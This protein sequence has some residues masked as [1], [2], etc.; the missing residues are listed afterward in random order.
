MVAFT[1]HDLLFIL[2]GIDVSEQH[3]A[4]SNADAIGGTWN[5]I[6]IEDSRIILRSLL[7][8][9]LEPIGMRTITGQLNNLEPA[10]T[11]FGAVGEFPRLLDPDYRD[12]GATG[13]PEDPIDING[14]APGGIVDNTDY[15]QSVGS[16]GSP[17]GHVV[18][19]DPRMISNLIVDISIHNAAAADRAGL[20]LGDVAGTYD[21]GEDGIIGTDDDVGTESGALIIDPNGTPLD[22]DDFL[23]IPNVAPDEGLSAPFNAWMT[24]FGQ[25][26]D[27][28]LD[29]VGK[30]GSGTIFMP[31][32][33]DDPLVAGDDGI[34]GT[35]DD[36]APQQRF[37]VLTRSDVDAG[38]DGVLGTPDDVA[39]AFN[40][41]SPFVDQNQ[42]YTSHPSMQLFVREYLDNNEPLLVDHHGNPIPIGA[43]VATG[44]LIEGAGGG[45]ANWG[46]VKAQA[47]LR[48]G[49]ELTDADGL[50]MPLFAVD[51][52]GEMIRGA[53]GL[54]QF[55]M[56]DGT[57]IE[58][59]LTSPVSL[60]DAVLA[61][62]APA[63]ARTGFSFLV[64][65]NNDANPVDSQTG[66]MLLR[67]EDGDATNG[68]AG[69]G[70]YDG[71]LL[72]AHY[73][74]GDGR[75]NENF[76]LTA[77][78][79]VFHQEHNRVVEHTKEVL[80]SQANNV[81]LG[82]L[83]D[84]DGT[85]AALDLLNG[86]LRVP[87]ATFPSTPGEIAGLVWDGD[88]LFQAAKFATEMQYQHLVFEEFGRKVQPLIDIFASFEPSIDAS[89]VAE[90]AH[91]VYRFGHSMLTE[92]VDLMDVDGNLTE[93][94]LIEAFLNPL[95]FHQ[96]VNEDGEIPGGSPALNASEAA[97]AIARGMTRQVGS[98]ID[99]FV[100]G[101]LRNNL[102]G[103]PLDLAAINI[104]RGRDTGVP[105]LNDARAE[106]FAGTGD[107][108][109]KPYDSWFD[110]AIH[111]KNEMSIV[112]FIAAYGQ[113]DTITTA[114]SIEMKRAASWTLVTGEATSGTD[115]N[116]DSYA[117]SVGTTSGDRLEFLH[118]RDDDGLG[119]DWSTAESGLN[120]VDFWI[121]GLAEAIEPFGGMLGSTFNFVFEEQME[122][123]QDGDRFYYLGRT[124]GL[125]FLTQ[126][127]ENSFA[128]M[129]IRNTSIGD[130]HD[131]DGLGGDHLP[132]DIFSSPHYILEVNQERQV[133][134]IDLPDAAIM[135]SG[136][137]STDQAS[138]GTWH[139]VTFTQEISNAVVAMMVNTTADADPTTVR[140]R[141][142][143]ETGF[144][145]QMDEYDYL[146][147]IHGL[148]TIS[149]VAVAEGEH[150]LADG[151]IIKAGTATENG[152]GSITVP[153]GG[154]TAFTTTP[155]VL[156]QVSSVNEETAV[157]SQVRTSGT[158]TFN[159]RLREQEA[160]SNP[161]GPGLQGTAIGSN[162]HAAETIGWIA[163]QQGSGALL[164][165]GTA[166]PVDE[167]PVTLTHS[168]G[169]TNPVFIGEIQTP[170]G[171]ANPATVRGTA[172]DPNAATVFLEEEASAS[173][174]N[175]SNE[176]VGFL[177]LPTGVIT[178][179]NPLNGR[180]DPDDG[181]LLVDTVIRQD[182]DNDGDN[183]YLRYTGGDHVVLGGTDEADTL[184]G[185]IGD[186]TL[187]G[188]D[189]DDRIEG[190]DGADILLGG[191]GDD[192]ITDLGG[193]D[194]I[195]GQAGN[196]AIYSGAGEDLILAGSGQDFVLQGEDLSE[197]FG[198]TGNDFMHLGSE[199]NLSFGGEGN[200]WMEGGDG[201]NLLQ[202]DNGDPFLNSTVGGHDVFISGQGDDDYDTEG[203]DDIMEGSDGVQRF[204]GVNGFD[205]ATY[206]DVQ[207][208]INVDMLLR[209]FDETPIPPSNA[210]I[211]DRFDS[212]E[213]LSGGHGSD[214]LRGSD[215]IR[216]EIEGVNNGNDSVLRTDERFELIRGLRE[217]DNGGLFDSVAIFDSTVTE[218]GEGD[219]ILGGSGSDLIEGRGGDDI[220]DGDLKLDVRIA[221]TVQVD[222]GVLVT[223]REM[224]GELFNTNPDG[225]ANYASPYTTPGGAT[226]L[227]EAVFAGEINPGDLNIVREILDESAASDYDI[228][229]FN[230]ALAEYTIEGR[231]A[232]AGVDGILGT[233]D[234]V[235]T[236]E[237]ADT[238]L[239]GY[240][241]VTH[242]SAPGANDGLGADGTDLVRNIERLQFAELTVEIPVGVTGSSSTNG[243]AG[244]QPVIVLPGT[245]TPALDP[246]VGDELEV[247]TS[248]ITDPN[249]MTDPIFVFTWQI[250]EAPGT[251]IDLEQI[252]LADITLL[253]GNPITVPPE[254]AGFPLRVRAM[255][256]DDAGVIEQVFSAATNITAPAAADVGTPGPDLLLG[257]PDNDTINGLAGNDQ[258]FALAGND[259]VNAGGNDDVVFGGD[260][261][262]TIRGNGG[263]DELFGEGGNDT[264]DG[265][266]GADLLDG[267]DGND[268]LRGDNGAD[269]ILGGA[270]EDRL[271]GGDGADSL[272]GGAD[273]D[274]VRGQGGDDE[275]LWAV[276]DGRDTVIG[277]G[278][279]DV[280]DVT[281][282]ALVAET[283]RV[284]AVTA[285]NDP[286]AL[287][288]N[289]IASTLDPAT[290]I[291]VLH[292]GA[293]I[294]ELR[295]IEELVINGT[296]TPAT[297]G[298]AAGD[299]VLVQG[300]FTNTSLALA[301]ITVNGSSGD[302]VV[303]ISG[304]DSAHRIVFRSFGGN[305][306]VVGNLRAQDVI[307]LAPGLDPA[308]FGPP[309]YNGNNTW[310]IS[311][312]GGGQ[313]I[314]YA[315]GPGAAAPTLAAH[316]ITEGFDFTVDDV[317]ELK[318]IVRGLPSDNLS[319]EHATGVRDLEGT[320]N[321]TAHPD[322]GAADQE[323]I[324]LTDARYGE[325]DATIG[326]HKVNPIFDGLDPREIS[327]ILG[328]QEDDLG[329]NK[330]G[331][332]TFFMA[333]GQYV[334]HGLDFLP[335]T[336][337]NGTIEIG[338][339]PQDDPADLT[340]GEVSSIA[341]GASEHLNKASPFVDQNQAYGSTE[342]VG[343]FLRESDGNQGHGPRLLSG[344]PDP[345]SPEY[346]LLPTLRELIIHH[347][348]NDTIFSDPVHMPGGPTSF[349]DYFPGLVTE[350]VGPGGTV[351]TINEAMVPALNADFMGSGHTLVGDANP[352]INLLDHYVAGDLRANENYSLTS[353]HTIWARNHNHHVE[354]L[355]ERGFDGTPDELFE[356]AK[357]VNEAEYQ[358]V[359]YTEFV[360]QLLGGM[361][362]SGGNHGHDDYDPTVDARISH[363]FAAAAYR[364]GHSL[365]S[366]TMTVIDENGDPQQIP[367]TDIFLN[368]TNDDAAFTVPLAQ[369]QQQGYIPQPGYEQI[370]VNGVVE[371]ISGQ[372]AEEVDFNIVDAVRD[373]LVRIRA[374]LF[375]F[376]VARGWD[377]GLGTLNQVRADLLKSSDPY[378]REA[379]GG[380]DADLTPYS[381]WEDFRSRNNLS[382]NVMGQLIAAYPDLELQTPAEIAAFQ[383]ANPY[384]ELHGP[385]GNIVRGIDRLDVWVG[386]LAEAHVNDGMVGSTFWVILHEQ[387]DRLQEGD[388][389]YYFDRVEKFDFY[390][391]VEDQTFSDIIERNTGLQ[392]LA[393]EIFS[394]PG[395]GEV[396]DEE[397][398]VGTNGKDT[399]FAFDEDATILGLGGHD[400]I[401]G[402]A[403]ADTIF[404]GGGNDQIVAGDGNDVIFG[405]GGRDVILAEGG[406]DIIYA[407]GGRDRVMSG[408]GNDFIEAGNGRD[409]IDAGDG[410]DTVLAEVGDGN[411]TIDGGAGNDTLDYSAIDS[412]IIA[413]LGDDFFGF[414]SS[415]DSG[416][417]SITNFE[418]I[419]TGS[420][421]DIIY[422]N[423]S[424]NVFSGGL[425]FD[426]FVF[427]SIEQ[428]D[429]D[430]IVDFELGDAIDLTGITT[431]Y[432]FGGFGDFELL[433][434]G[435]TTFTQAGQLIVRKDSGS[436]FVE[437]NVDGDTD[438]DF[439][440]K[441]SGISKLEPLDFFGVS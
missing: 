130:Q 25:F 341:N 394:V 173:G 230:G 281:G 393:E 242:N 270:G 203:G 83:G 200:D 319:E 292:N 19:T 164:T 318:N 348:Q 392:G 231:V 21:A 362:G 261:N 339:D 333:F 87:V 133:T 94:G 232:A 433:A 419:V 98:E 328:D 382:L 305:D 213:G 253:Q 334:D 302:D 115:V 275:I 124:G 221:G 223:A 59:N 188:E 415:V 425:G 291:V 178:A 179:P 312:I 92:T 297:G 357:I 249:G 408:D 168:G 252:G 244:G 186:D 358:R 36:L 31:L 424:A 13:N 18:D 113:H 15:S 8:N 300:D 172:F 254:A 24:F 438:A 141:N 439:T 389:F 199:S 226:T 45:M 388:R 402:G 123:L 338:T 93:A 245:T 49:I 204:E 90:F 189:G 274:D 324:R 11:E 148:E 315:G 155:V 360:D 403:H 421:D 192:I 40:F 79:H 54:P 400:T 219:I 106:F 296:D 363:E 417:D 103:L 39:D 95:G 279:T 28:G 364:F 38:P 268:L 212:V 35:I 88:R 345:S 355:L 218:W 316:S 46:E 170:I 162:A 201:N 101:A 329:P 271:R 195:Q 359:V 248:A 375:A 289:P 157:T 191:D 336:A 96:S 194:N 151:S 118:S 386:G 104:A 193:E 317:R 420:G 434:E 139:T 227:Q 63:A 376:N 349:Q 86:Y 117:F 116:G 112:N 397:Q 303:D 239:D 149:W 169:Y 110:F 264:I 22:H 237:A 327:N 422:A 160:G 91:T 122:D 132:G 33:D 290:E 85:A 175:T 34:F 109:L 26:F 225:S 229:E 410:D 81:D 416:E 143:T 414:V 378:V 350:S 343:Q 366:Q 368:P 16:L 58:G 335:K 114:T 6:D 75:V 215:Q 413:D 135:E 76:G 60:A 405:D 167:T 152:S 299:T 391:Q 121:G 156:S 370:G 431:N 321:N 119:T 284:V 73:I 211:L 233:A 399:L 323:F 263:L 310:T 174:T 136:T 262:D 129:I 427:D 361:L 207:E 240:I 2:E 42:T 266:N 373:D 27:H 216:L 125:N 68:G 273:D 432:N 286:V 356:A 250:E 126:L 369:L 190:G 65:I 246:Q 278:G 51:E 89:I 206:R 55:V 372:P 241:T 283:F 381:S 325:F 41:T 29:L 304:L 298:F 7:P 280:F 390:D 3:A 307:E 183:D 429:G 128:N 154:S 320:G 66:L 383:A 134:G 436:L 78:H 17:D 181:N 131:L 210:T 428:A 385:G 69:A 331:A 404:G 142:I 105:T 202:G 171:A 426:T 4:Q 276:G 285:P 269:E 365:I 437:G 398:I 367:L 30:G 272:A 163:I 430:Y 326:N 161:L 309:V 265:D 214:V 371:G 197:A 61:H 196:D 1:K 10:Q 102:L 228:A 257:T 165:A 395:H 43:P 267:G 138:P 353:I 301:T 235:V 23:F 208:G 99:E 82:T 182:L 238:N 62:G 354:S 384:I 72:D 407:G 137:V 176:T 180:G 314:T 67:H 377:V 379:V 251:W 380:V 322:F 32:M 258:I 20:D 311:Q 247:D 306:T 111:L 150:I 44:H 12:D 308:D 71:D 255:F 435:T 50:N 222:G 209:A 205:W 351:Y 313:S 64:D 418:N 127:E 53:S 401:V 409:Y 77:V 234:D 187:W 352:F 347:W 340:R 57:L 37:M 47:A 159:L 140:V 84:E 14:P 406:D 259:V 342:L 166:A 256:Q 184:I 217:G 100:T 52:Y 412:D 344:A 153:F 346:A 107:T 294:A 330:E 144:Q 295:T 185:G 108:K 198:G 287:L 70:E 423:T 147:G 5:P 158:A 243:I 56:A 441:V 120:L 332:N 374:D 440:I 411:D 220:I 9:S 236:T 337:A 396:E 224:Y 177:T 387:F 146:D 74:A 48:L 293:V 282:D 80:L 260:G 288:G 97:G 277:G 145:F